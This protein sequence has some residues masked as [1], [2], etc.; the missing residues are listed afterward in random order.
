VLLGL[1]VWVLVLDL[2]A[3]PAESFV[4]A[5]CGYALAAAI[6]MVA[7]FLP[8]GIGLR[9]VILVL[10]LTG[11]LDRSAASAVVILSRFVITASDVA[12]AGLGWLYDRTHHLMAARRGDGAGPTVS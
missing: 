9:E 12:A 4:P 7:V 10:L 11:P 8:A 3:S 5:V 2:G 6:G 1:Q